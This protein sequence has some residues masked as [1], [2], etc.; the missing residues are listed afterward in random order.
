MP[1]TWTHVGRCWTNGEPFLAMDAGLLA[2]WR[3]MSDSAYEELVPHL[4]YETTSV[5]VGPGSAGLI[6]TDP[7]VGDEGWL[8]VFRSPDGSVAIVQAG[9]PDHRGVVA[10]ALAHPTDGDQPGDPVEVPSGRLA[11]ISA[12]LDGTGPDGASLSRE[13]PGPT[14]SSAAYDAD[15]DDAG[16]PLLEVGARTLRLSVRWMVELGGEA[17]FARWLLTAD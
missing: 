4:G 17:V 1:P 11:L 6:L 15:V 14:P 12:A 5:R 8:E 9:G 3:G 10:A 13:R 2:H 16:A 7:E